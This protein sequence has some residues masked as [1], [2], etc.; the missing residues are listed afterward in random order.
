MSGLV[1]TDLKLQEHCKNKVKLDYYPVYRIANGG[2]KIY[3]TRP[4][5]LTSDCSAK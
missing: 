5:D 2:T 4:T 3:F 1:F